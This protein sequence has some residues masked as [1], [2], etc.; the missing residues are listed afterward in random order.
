ME[1][2]ETEHK[3]YTAILVVAG[4]IIF[5][6]ITES[7]GYTT[8][9]V[10]AVVASVL[11]LGLTFG[12]KPTENKKKIK[13]TPNKNEEIEQL[14]KE[15]EQLK[16]N[17]QQQIQQEIEPEQEQKNEEIEMLK[18]EISELKNILTPLQKEQKIKQ[19]KKFIEEYESKGGN[20]VKF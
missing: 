3:I 5:M 8:D 15:I 13:K 11:N 14:K 17:N 2:K 16:N 12:I 6:K 9:A 10:F 4:T 19:I 20:N 1:I 18:S 7:L